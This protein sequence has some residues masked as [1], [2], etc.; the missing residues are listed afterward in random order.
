MQRTTVGLIV[1]L[2]LDVLVA[3]LASNAQQST[4]RLPS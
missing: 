2:A 1:L 4:L 3:P